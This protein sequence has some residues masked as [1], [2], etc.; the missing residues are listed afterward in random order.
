MD[1]VPRELFHNLPA[2][3]RP[4]ARYGD[5]G[6]VRSEVCFTHPHGPGAVVVHTP[7]MD[8]SNGAGA[9]DKPEMHRFVA[10]CPAPQARRVSDDIF[11]RIE[12]EAFEFRAALAIVSVVHVAMPQM[13]QL[14]LHE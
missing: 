4:V 10:T 14:A 2:T 5:A 11:E 1:A 13:K 12:G 6:D 8:V 3:G 7:S 9:S